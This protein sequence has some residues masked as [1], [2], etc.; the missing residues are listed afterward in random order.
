MPYTLLYFIAILGLASASPFIRLAAAPLEV[1][2][3]W[4]LVL[5]AICFAP[6]AL[7]KG[8]F[9][10]E[11]APH[12]LICGVLFFGHLWSFFYATQ[13]TSIANSMIL[14]STNPLF[15]ALGAFL[16]FKEKLPRRVI[17]AYLLAIAG[18]YQLVQHNLNFAPEHLSGDLAGLLSGVLLSAYILTGNQARKTLSNVDFSF[19][20]YLVVGVL[21]GLTAYFRQEN[22]WNY[23]TITW[24]SI[25]GLVIFP[26]LL[27]H[28]LFMYLLRHMNINLMSCGKL[29][30]PPLATLAAYFLFHEEMQANTWIAFVLTASSV[31]ILFLP[32]Q[33]LRW[34]R[35]WLESGE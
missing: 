17:F 20:V 34:M 9:K 28:V 6:F 30:E 10:N 12:A 27:G 11:K 32:W 3:F 22:F 5:C 25:A 33:K 24:A 15:T 26:T 21:F 29:L 1:I 7:R 31:L 13:N 16:F 2:G 14:Y 23:P 35:F 8:L 4:R 19:L 18:T